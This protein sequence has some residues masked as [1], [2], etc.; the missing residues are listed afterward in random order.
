[1]TP[2]AFLT[3]EGPCMRFADANQLL[4]A[5]ISR[6]ESDWIRHDDGRAHVAAR[7]H[8]IGGTAAMAEWWLG[9]VHTTE[10]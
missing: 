4:D 8:M 6:F 10:Q 1:M 7:A 2:N 3:T 9:Y 5:A